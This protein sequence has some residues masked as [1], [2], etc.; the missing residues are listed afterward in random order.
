MTHSRF[1]VGTAAHA[2]LATP[3][4]LAMARLNPCAAA[5]APPRLADASTRR[6]SPC[7]FAK[8]QTRMRSTMGG[9][10]GL[11]G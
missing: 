2:E 4:E 6:R 3:M 1:A 5:H 7:S 9:R 8:G 10:R 11:H